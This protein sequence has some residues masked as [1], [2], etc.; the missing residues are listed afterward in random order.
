MIFQA[1][2]L[3]IFVYL[4]L[5]LLFKKAKYRHPPGPTGG[6]PLIGYFPSY[7]GL[8]PYE[9]LDRWAKKYGP[10][11]T[12]KIGGRSYYVLNSYD[13]IRSAYVHDGNGNNFLD[14]PQDFNLLGSLFEFK[15]LAFTNGPEWALQRKLLSSLIRR[16]LVAVEASIIQSG[17]EIVQRIQKLPVGPVDLYPILT[18]AVLNVVSQLFRIKI[19]A[20]FPSPPN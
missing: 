11:F 15:A 13:M 17:Q 6:I 8:K 10:I 1:I 4:P 14:R 2:L 18:E 20:I 5:F 7:L 19:L 3:V 16:N 12:L 9:L